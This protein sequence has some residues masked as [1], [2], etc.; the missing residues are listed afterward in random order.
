MP[1]AEEIPVAPRSEAK[2]L[3]QPIM[4]Q[5]PQQPIAPRI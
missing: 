4:Q 2:E 3:Q 1:K 5:Q